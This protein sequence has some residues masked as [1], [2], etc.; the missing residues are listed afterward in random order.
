MS[1]QKILYMLIGPKGAGKTYIGKLINQHTDIA[2]LQVELIWLGLQSGEDGWEKVETA[3]DTMFQTHSKVMIE[4]LGAGEGFLRLY[5]ALAKKY[6]IK[7]IRVYAN[8]ETCLTRVKSR[9]SVDHIV[10]SDVK[11]IEYNIAAATVVYDWDLEI[12]NNHPASDNDILTAI[13]S[14]GAVR[15]K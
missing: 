7:M 12:D 3:I 4:S 8:P 11:V 2:F 9:S 10:V 14:I 1:N 15:C 13:Q 6:S 5:S